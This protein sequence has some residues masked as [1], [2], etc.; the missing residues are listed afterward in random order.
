M[1]RK[2]YYVH[3]SEESILLRCHFFP[4]GSTDVL[5]PKQNSDELLAEIY[6]LTIWKSKD[7][8]Q[9]KANKKIL[10]IMKL[11]IFSLADLNTWYKTTV[12][13]TVQQTDKQIKQING[14]EKRPEV[15]SH[16]YGQLLFNKDTKVIQ[17]NKG[18]V[19]CKQVV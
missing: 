17:R 8:K 16:M 10:K 2:I 11:E 6:K 3:K 14:I 19:F 18:R 1:N 4:N 13:K 9:K 15:D 7:L 12:I 5:Q